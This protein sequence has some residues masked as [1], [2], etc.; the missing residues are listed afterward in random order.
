MISEMLGYK[1]KAENDLTVRSIAKYNM[2]RNT[3]PV[4]IEVEFINNGNLNIS[5]KNPD[6]VFIDNIQ[7]SLWN[8]MLFFHNNQLRLDASFF[9]IELNND[10]FVLFDNNRNHKF[11]IS[12]ST[13]TQY[14]IIPSK[15]ICLDF[16]SQQEDSY[17]YY[18]KFDKFNFDFQKRSRLFW[19]FV[20]EEEI[21]VYHR[22]NT[23]FSSP[24]SIFMTKI[25]SFLFS[26]LRRNVKE[27]KEIK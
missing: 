27:V 16:A 15:T 14:S 8:Q 11:L 1:V 17:V 6:I 2:P 19:S 23:F 18:F 12:N 4:E 9:L 7:A 25:Q 21:I 26:Y 22:D 3:Y 20:N 13:G 24:I 5:I 10:E